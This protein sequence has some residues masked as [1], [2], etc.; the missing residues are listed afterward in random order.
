VID[1]FA[2]ALYAPGYVLSAVAMAVASSERTLALGVYSS[3]V[4]LY[5][6]SARVFREPIFLYPAAWLVAVPYYIGLTFTSLPQDWYGLAWLPLIVGYIVIARLVFQKSPLG[7]KDLR[8][9]FQALEQPSMPFYTLAYGLSVSMMVLSLGDT[10]TLSLALIA[11]SVIYF[12]SAALFRNYGWLYP[13]LLTTHF[14]VGALYN[15]LPLNLPSHYITLPFLIL[16]WI[17]ALVGRHFEKRFP[18]ADEAEVEKLSLKLLGFEV[19]FGRLPHLDHIFTPSW[20]QPFFI[21]VIL[22]VF[23]WQALALEGLDT[24]IILAVGNALLIAFFS[25]DWKDSILSYSALAFL[26]MGA[27]FRLSWTAMPPAEIFAWLSGLGCLLY[28]IAMI[29]EQTASGEVLRFRSL[30]IWVKPMTWTAILLTAVGVLVTLPQV[31]TYGVAATASLGFAGMFYLTLAYVKRNTNLSYLGLAL[32]EF[33]WVLILIDQEI[34]Q[35]QLYAIPAGLYFVLVGYLE[36]GRGRKLFATILEGFGLAVILITSFIQ[37]IEGASGFPYFLLLLIEGV[38]VVWWGAMQ[39]RKVP[40][41]MG[42]GASVL[43]VVSQVILLVNI[44]DV[45]RWIIIL[46]VG[47][48]LV[49]AA[50]FVERKR[51]QIIAQTQEWLEALE[52]WD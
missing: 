4:L 15:H 44:Y 25:M 27:F 21:F 33:D 41:F 9:F 2:M 30:S 36:R 51:E 48:L 28:L 22:D 6:L 8:S 26:I 34:K 40:F 50:V 18:Q 10:L 38:L 45:Q 35:P 1:P 37:S 5:A 23:L 49:S 17:L 3:A 32:L 7:I 19:D 42:I 43:A 12:A 11:S 39:R 14:A 13:A 20:A 46:G 29:A 24:A 47:L 52:A 16:L 31:R